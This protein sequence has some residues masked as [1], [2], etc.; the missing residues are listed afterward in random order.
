[1]YM[2]SVICSV[3]A[4]AITLYVIHEHQ[5]QNKY[6]KLQNKTYGKQGFTNV[7]PFLHT[8]LILET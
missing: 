6:V 5:S 2:N 8:F 3:T 4:F 1:M 7:M